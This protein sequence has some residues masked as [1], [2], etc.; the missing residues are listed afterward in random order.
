MVR[1]RRGRRRRRQDNGIA[2]ATSPSS[3]VTSDGPPEVSYQL[4]VAFF[5]IDREDVIRRGGV[6]WQVF[7]FYPRRETCPIFFCREKT[8]SSPSS[9][10]IL[11][12][13]KSRLLIYDERDFLSHA[14]YKKKSLMQMAAFRANKFTSFVVWEAL[15]SQ[16]S[17]WVIKKQN[18]NHFTIIPSSFWRFCDE[19]LSLNNEER[20]T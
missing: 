7:L 14:F 3:F 8:R 18:L 12:K 15:S 20:F 9:H 6:P 4:V 11:K 13:K 19:D 1:R 5:L 16:L 10:L 2:R 17:T